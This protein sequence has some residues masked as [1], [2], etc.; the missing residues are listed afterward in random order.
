MSAFIYNHFL[1][2]VFLRGRAQ[3]WGLCDLQLQFRVWLGG[4]RPWEINIVALLFCLRLNYRFENSHCQSEF[5]CTV[6]TTG[7]LFHPTTYYPCSLCMTL[8]FSASSVACSML[9]MEKLAIIVTAFS[10]STTFLIWVEMQHRGIVFFLYSYLLTN[11]L[12]QP[13][14]VN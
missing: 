1:D 2:F 7:K 4:W 5:S 13:L 8:A 3:E 14:L 9:T 12:L 10:W 11:W 6:V